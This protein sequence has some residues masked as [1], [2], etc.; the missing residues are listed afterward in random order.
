VIEVIVR[1]IIQETPDIRRLTLAPTGGAIFPAFEAGSHVDLH[2]PN[3]L[4]RQYS[5]INGP[6]ETDTYQ[7]GVLKETTSRG[8]SLWIHETLAKDDRLRISAPRNLFPVAKLA[9][10][11]ILFAG[12]IGITP[13]LSMARH[14]SASRA[15]FE[16][17]YSARN[18]REAAFYPDL[19]S[20]TGGRVQLHA[21]GRD[22]ARTVFLDALS[23]PSPDTHVYICGPSG[24]IQAILELARQQGWPDSQLHMEAFG[25]LPSPSDASAYAFTIQLARSGATIQVASDQTVTQALQAHGFDV[26]VSCEQGICGTCL[27][28]VISGVPDHR[29]QY[30][31]DEER[32]A[33]DQFT[34]C[35]SRARSSE[36][37]LDL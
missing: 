8:G 24:Y 18:R 19:T 10:R 4:V 11:H 29:D 34:P 23:H 3:G 22:V 37:V 32:A 9:Q 35:C 30:L 20:L 33:N 28:R 14:L 7:L 1:D 31:T 17:H 5:L 6:G 15:D 26:P 2:L 12:G 13:I 21:D 36:L 16:V 25:A 27:T